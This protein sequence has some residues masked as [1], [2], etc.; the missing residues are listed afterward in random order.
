MVRRS[1]GE[2]FGFR[3]RDRRSNGSPGRRTGR[4]QYE[5]ER[6]DAIMYVTWQ[7]LAA[8]LHLA[9]RAVGERHY[10]TRW[11]PRPCV[12]SPNPRLLEARHSY[13]KMFHHLRFSRSNV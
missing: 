11:A 13:D 4:R 8:L 6:K 5:A 10:F 3:D 12:P 1:G 2:G 9:D 7:Q